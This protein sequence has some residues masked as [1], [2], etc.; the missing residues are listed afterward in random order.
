MTSW[1]YILMWHIITGWIPYGRYGTEYKFMIGGSSSIHSQDITSFDHGTAKAMKW[2]GNSE[3]FKN[4]NFRKYQTQ[5]GRICWMRMQVPS[6]WWVQF[7]CC[8]KIP[9]SNGPYFISWSITRLD[10][11]TVSLFLKFN[12]WLKKP[13]E[14]TSWLVQRVWVTIPGLKTWGP[15]D[16]LPSGNLT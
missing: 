13:E 1:P 9:I 5:Q 14:K 16:D 10:G 6:F 8:T 2:W 4:I 7:F 3:L 12:P 11:S 15:T